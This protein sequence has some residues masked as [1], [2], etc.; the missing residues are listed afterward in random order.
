MI[1]EAEHC[2]IYR[3]TPPLLQGPWSIVELAWITPVG[4]HEIVLVVRDDQVFL[5][6][7]RG[8]QMPVD[9]QA[10][11]DLQQQAH[12]HI[13]YRETSAQGEGWK[14]RYRCYEGRLA[15]VCR[16]ILDEGEGLPGGLGREVTQCDLEISVP[17]LRLGDGPRWKK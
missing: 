14:G 10:T 12:H 1:K 8:D 5:A 16:F 6:N 13:R 3:A 15:G 7:R 11:R 4:S 2:R 9:P 17:P